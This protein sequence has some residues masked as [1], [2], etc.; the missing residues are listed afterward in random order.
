MEI[1]GKY[2]NILL[3]PQLVDDLGFGE[4]WGESGEFGSRNLHDPQDE[5]NSLMRIYDMDE[6]EGGSYGGGWVDASP[7]R[8]CDTDFS[9]L[10]TLE[11]LLL[12]AEAKY[13]LAFP[14]LLANAN[15][16]IAA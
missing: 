16:V 1:S 3:T 7:R 5:Y 13:P 10:N 14:I 8:F 12:N 9:Y 15:K 4:Y 11:D 6:W 2:K